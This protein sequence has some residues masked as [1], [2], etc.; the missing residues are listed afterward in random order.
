MSRGKSVDYTQP[1]I[2]RR[3][4]EQYRQLAESTKLR[5]LQDMSE[6]EIRALERQYGCTV[7]RPAVRPRRGRVR[8]AA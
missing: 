3:T 1:S 6:R 7:I 8:R 4:D 2:S 5:T